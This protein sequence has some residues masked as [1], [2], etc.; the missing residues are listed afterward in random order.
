MLTAW[1]DIEGKIVKAFADQGT[2]RDLNIGPAIIP[3]K[4]HARG[5]FQQIANGGAF[6]ALCKAT[7]GT[8]VLALCKLDRIVARACAQ[9][10]QISKYAVG[11]GEGTAFLHQKIQVQPCLDRFFRFFRTRV[12][13]GQRRA[14]FNGERTVRT[15]HIA[16][17]IQCDGLADIRIVARQCPI[18][19]QF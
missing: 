7:E 5:C 19:Q 16:V 13:D 18:C 17:Q 3:V 2:S 11:A 15:E 9:Q 1:T 12:L 8:V 6:I 4:R 10:P 14:V